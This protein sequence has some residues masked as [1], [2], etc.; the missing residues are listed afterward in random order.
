[1]FFLWRI[2]GFRR[3]VVLFLLRQAWRMIRG[4]QARR[5][6]RPSTGIDAT[7]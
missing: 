2:A 4:R 3:L 1:M 7:V 6:T 5:R